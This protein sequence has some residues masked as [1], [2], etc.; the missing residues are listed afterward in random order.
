MTLIGRQGRS[1]A[2]PEMCYHRAMQLPPSTAPRMARWQIVLPVLRELGI[3]QVALYALY[4]LGLRSGH[5]QRACNAEVAAR[6]ADSL[7]LQAICPIWRIPVKDDLMASLGEPGRARLLSEADE[8]ASGQV[9]LFGGPLVPLQLALPG[10]LMNWT[11]YERGARADDEDVKW[12][13]EP[14]RLGWAYTLGRAYLTSQDERYAAAFWRFIETFLE[15]SPPY[16]GPHWVSAQ[17]VALRLIA[18]TFCWQVFGA[19]DC[20]HPPQAA[21]LAQAVA[22]HAARIPP[23][24]VYARAQNNNHLLTEAAGLYTAGLFLP[25][26]PAAERW[27]SLGWRWF[28]HGIQ[29]QIARDGTYVQHSTNYHR[30]MLQIALWVSCLAEGQ[31]LALPDKTRERLAA[32]ARWLLT[33]PDSECGRVPNLGPNDGAYILPLTICPHNDYRPVLQAAAGAFLG[34]RPYAT[35]AWDEMGLWLG[36]RG[37]AAAKPGSTVGMGYAGDQTPHVL[38]SPDGASWAYLRAA[39]FTGRPGHADQL[40]LDVWWRGLNVAQDAG[41]YLYNAPPPWDNALARSDA[42]NTVVIDGQDQMRRAG[43]FLYVDWAQVEVLKQDRWG[44]GSQRFISTRHDGY[45]RFGLWHQRDVAAGADGVWEIVDTINPVETHDAEVS[46]RATLHWLLP[47]WPWEVQ[48][49]PEAAGFVIAL[50]S[51]HGPVRLWLKWSPAEKPSPLEALQIAR[52][53][54]RVWGSGAVSPTWGWSSPTYGL[55]VP[56]LSVRFTL[57]GPTPV[58]F[59]TQ[60][61][62]PPGP[63]AE[64]Q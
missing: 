18:L 20:A 6:Q 40:H 31:G 26:H 5:Y 30:L 29:A 36:G 48:T 13:W 39:R 21:R 24:L 23:T 61:T 57:T 9:R 2:S 33:L 60:F 42:H 10:P 17:E 38:R 4:Q 64:E 63:K 53:G 27:R 49:A 32:A 50:D 16:Q 62:F 37:A 56:A 51:P 12:T 35:G 47:D 58:C 22:V 45:R 25:D 15:A 41:T 52:A 43:R 3:R 14:G 55:K 28:N 44:D 46:H 11:A 54:E 1:E 19:A 7:D 34:E 8:I 59:T